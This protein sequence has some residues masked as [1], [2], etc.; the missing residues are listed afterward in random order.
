MEGQSGQNENLVFSLVLESRMRYLLERECR[1][2]KK[3]HSRKLNKK[4]HDRIDDELKVQR[5]DPRRFLVP[6]PVPISEEQASQMLREISPIDK[7]I[8]EVENEEPKV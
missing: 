3:G 5:F 6:L 8:E 2:N 1:A 7:A 4:D